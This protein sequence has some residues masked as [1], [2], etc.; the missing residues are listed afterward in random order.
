MFR[1]IVIVQFYQKLIIMSEPKKFNPMTM[2]I[3]SL[4]IFTILF[5]YLITDTPSEE[6]YWLVRVL[7]AL[8]A[9]SMSMSLS[10]TIRV[11]GKDDAVQTM[12]EK[13]PKITAVGALAV[14]VI[15][16]LFNPISIV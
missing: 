15:V 8:A 5:V 7:A 12:A 6:A 9:A 11:G 2:L 14:F 16:Y 4:I 3:V 13:E 1:C 10:G